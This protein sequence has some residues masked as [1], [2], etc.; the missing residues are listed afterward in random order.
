MGSS[1]IDGVAQIVDALLLDKS[2][3][4]K[5]NDW[6]ELYESDGRACPPQVREDFELSEHRFITPKGQK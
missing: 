2:L 1:W 3:L 6:I 5:L 4:Q